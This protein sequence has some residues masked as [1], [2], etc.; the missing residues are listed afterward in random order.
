MLPVLNA[1]TSP[2]QNQDVPMPVSKGSTRVYFPKVIEARELLKE[3]A[4]ELYEEYRALAADAKGLGKVDIAE[5]ILWNL[6]AHMPNEDGQRMIDSDASQPKELEGPR[7]PQIAIGIQL[8][9]V[10]QKVLP[11][12]EVID[13]KPIKE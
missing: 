10:D 12:A 4:I 5:K 2:K 3:K 8:G 9:G 1:Q 13:V 7:G 6:I 11:A